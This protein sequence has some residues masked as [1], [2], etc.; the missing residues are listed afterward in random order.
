M[1]DININPNVN[2]P[3]LYHVLRQHLHPDML[4]EECIMSMSDDL[5]EN[6]DEI[7]CYLIP[8]M[9]QAIDKEINELADETEGGALS[10]V[11]TWLSLMY[12]GNVRSDEVRECFT[13]GCVTHEDIIKG[14]IASIQTDDSMDFDADADG[15]DDEYDD[16]TDGE[17]WKQA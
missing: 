17:E 7:Q 3:M 5:K 6:G 16:D 1:P 10:T 15:Y 9:M 11:L 4:T 14:F 13:D 12:V 8:G 2:S